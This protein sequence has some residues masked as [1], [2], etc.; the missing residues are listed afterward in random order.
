MAY[1]VSPPNEYFKRDSRFWWKP[2]RVFIPAWSFSL[3]QAALDGNA[4][5][6][7][8]V[9]I[10][11]ASAANWEEINS[12]GVSGLD[13]ST[14]AEE[15]NTLQML[16]YDLDIKHPVYVRVHYTTGS[17]DTADTVLWKVRY[18]PIQPNV[19]EIVSAA[20]ALDEVIAT[21]TIPVA[22]AYVWTATEWGRINANTLT[23]R[24]EAIQWEVEMDTKD[25]DISEDIF[26]LGLEIRYTPKR[27]QYRDGMKH[28][29]KAGTFMLADISSN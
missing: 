5:N 6:A 14:D 21:D 1:E 9:L 19:T 22:T 13:M 11:A 12:L 29:A 28:E 16:P 23:N 4:A 26:F 17:S 24:V 10:S 3:Q 27:L 25:T 8:T 18:L 7:D 15:V 2:S 20:T